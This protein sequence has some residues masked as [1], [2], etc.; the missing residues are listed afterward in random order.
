MDT[1]Q[2]WQWQRFSAASSSL[3][4][5]NSSTGGGRCGVGCGS[6][7]WRGSGHRTFSCMP[8]K[9]SEDWQRAAQSLQLLSC[10]GCCSARSGACCVRAAHFCHRKPAAS[11]E[12]ACQFTAYCG[13]LVIQGHGAVDWMSAL[14]GIRSGCLPPAV[15]PALLV[16]YGHGAQGLVSCNTA[17]N[18]HCQQHDSGLCMRMPQGRRLGARTRSW[19]RHM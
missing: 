16:T 12:R 5:P 6:G 9:S 7:G 19:R 3:C 14:A 17:T 10:R 18:A 8:N 13:L 11:A 15:I 1:W 2:T 4:A